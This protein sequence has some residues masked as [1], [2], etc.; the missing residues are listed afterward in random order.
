M[1]L[2]LTGFA[3]VCIGALLN[4]GW[5]YAMA[6]RAERR[7]LRTA[8]RLLLPELLQNKEHLETAFKTGSW[9][10]VQFGTDRWERHEVK[11]MSSLESEWVELVQIYTAFDLLN[12]DRKIREEEKRMES[13]LED[14]DDFDYF[15]LTL[16]AADRATSALRKVAG[17]APNESLRIQEFFWV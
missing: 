8:A 16:K 5:N 6:R 7:E 15:E 14:G 2:A 4:A 17:L 12:R 10:Y 3:G 13:I 1:L 9:S 11:F